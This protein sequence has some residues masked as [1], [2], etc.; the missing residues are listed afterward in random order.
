MK[1]AFHTGSVCNIILK[2]HS[3]KNL[4]KMMK[5]AYSYFYL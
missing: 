4:D 1:R 5:L 3:E 2:I